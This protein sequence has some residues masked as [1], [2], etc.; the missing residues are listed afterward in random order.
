MTKVKMMKKKYIG[1]SAA[2]AC[3]TIASIC[4]GMA[5]HLQSQ[6]SSNNLASTKVAEKSTLSTTNYAPV[7][8]SQNILPSISNY[9]YFGIQDETAGAKVTFTTFDGVLR[10]IFNPASIPLTDIPTPTPPP[11]SKAAGTVVS[12][13]VNLS[14][15][16]IVDVK[17]LLDQENAEVLV[18]GVFPEGTHNYKKHA[19][20]RLTSDGRYID[21][22]FILF[23]MPTFGITEEA[24]GSGDGLVVADV[25]KDIINNESGKIYSPYNLK[26]INTAKN[27]C[28]VQISANPLIIKTAT[29]DD[30]MDVNKYF[31]YKVNDPKNK[32]V[33]DK[34][35]YWADEDAFA[36]QTDKTDRAPIVL[37]KYNKINEN[38]KS[39]EIDP[40]TNKPINYTPASKFNT[41][42]K[43]PYTGTKKGYGDQFASDIVFYGLPSSN[44]VGFYAALMRPTAPAKEGG[45]VIEK[46]LSIYRNE[47]RNQ[48][49]FEPYGKIGNS[50]IVTQTNS[51]SNLFYGINSK[52]SAPNYYSGYTYSFKQFESLDPSRI[53][54]KMIIP[55]AS[56]KDD[57]CKYTFNVT[58]LNENSTI[59]GIL[60]WRFDNWLVNSNNNIKAAC[61]EPLYGS[62]F[63]IQETSGSY[64]VQFLQ[65]SALSNAQPNPQG[66][67]DTAF[68]KK[69][70]K[71]NTS[72]F[73]NDIQT[74]MLLDGTIFPVSP[75][76]NVF[77]GQD[78]DAL[79]ISYDF[80]FLNFGNNGT[81][82]TVEFNWNK[83]TPDKIAANLSTTVYNI[84]TFKDLQERAT[85]LGWVPKRKRLDDI[86]E[87]MVSTIGN[88]KN[89][90]GMTPPPLFYY[91]YTAKDHI[92][93]EDDAYLSVDKFT[94]VYKEDALEFNAIF[95]YKVYG[96]NQNAND[97]YRSYTASCR[98]D[99]FQKSPTSI[100][101]N[102]F[103]VPNKKDGRP[104]IVTSPLS[105]QGHFNVNPPSPYKIGDQVSFKGVE[106]TIGAFNLAATDT[107]VW[108]FIKTPPTNL[109]DI[110]DSNGNFK[111]SDAASLTKLKEIFQPVVVNQNGR[112]TIQTPY[113]N[114]YVSPERFK[115]VINPHSTYAVNDIVRD[116][117]NSNTLYIFTKAYNGSGQWNSCAEQFNGTDLSILL[118]NDLS[119]NQIAM[120][121][122][123]K[124]VGG[125]KPDGFNNNNISFAGPV[126][127]SNLSVDGKRSQITANFTI[128]NYYDNRGE[129]VST[130]SESHPA[131]INF[132]NYTIPTLFETKYNVSQFNGIL[133][134]NMYAY[135]VDTNFIN[136][137]PGFVEQIL[138]INRILHPEVAG[139]NDN[140]YTV[141]N[142]SVKD[143]TPNNRE[144]LV[145]LNVQ[146]NHWYD[147]SGS[148]VYDRPQSL[149]LTISGFKQAEETAINLRDSN[150]AQPYQI[151]LDP[152]DANVPGLN[153]A[154]PSESTVGDFATDDNIK[155]FILNYQKT[156]I[157]PENGRPTGFNATDI[158]ILKKNVNSDDG[159]LMV[160]LR[161]NKYFQEVNGTLFYYDNPP[162]SNQ[163][164]VDVYYLKISGFR[165]VP[166][167]TL[168]TFVYDGTI[169]IN[170][171]LKV[172]SEWPSQLSFNSISLPPIP[173][174][175]Y[176]DNQFPENIT[177]RNPAT[178]QD[179]ITNH[180]AGEPANI[181]TKALFSFLTT[182]N[183]DGKDNGQFL[184]GFGIDEIGN[185]T[186]VFYNNFTGKIVFRANLKKF[187][188]LSEDGTTTKVDNSSNTNWR[189][190]VSCRYSFALSGFE[191]TKPVEFVSDTNAQ[192]SPFLS[193]QTPNKDTPTIFNNFSAKVNVPNK[194]LFDIEYADIVNQLKWDG[195]LGYY[196]TVENGKQKLVYAK[197][198][199]LVKNNTDGIFAPAPYLSKNLAKETL[200]LN[201]VFAQDVYIF[202]MQGYSSNSVYINSNVGQETKILSG[203]KIIISIYNVK[204]FNMWE[205]VFWVAIG[206]IIFLLL[207]LIIM[208][209]VRKKH[210]KNI[211]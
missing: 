28:L 82:K 3:C 70:F 117:K 69:T 29:N 43:S 152:N 166:D 188:Q 110:F 151:T 194:N 163:P 174:I 119:S 133:N 206:V 37:L 83:S 73:G 150:A 153:G 35:K 8:A 94:R 86:D 115:G 85:E 142:F 147:D 1:W 30:R 160:T 199:D 181:I 158:A 34:T 192:G 64:Q 165:K 92:Y 68:V 109:T 78:D 18:L 50:E 10:W 88:F 62:F 19:I 198:S 205:I 23:N 75:S 4:L 41:T 45:A 59:S 132:S 130:P 157:I 184:S 66:V 113:A 101:T 116:D 89:A 124:M 5:N 180:L 167:V 211:Y 33:H 9:G 208:L 91:T 80:H 191:H 168:D 74:Q 58:A 189:T 182:P 197:M 79:N 126:H 111:K 24:T 100:T 31:S 155:N 107:Y 154:L 121:I 114:N 47:V 134:E 76:K 63:V 203:S 17:P 187:I 65:T 20:F 179:G 98:I 99:N 170:S 118:P 135:Q 137:N 172:S 171:S 104:L 67:I 6:S 144:G 49:F 149:I 122:A 201:Y 26:I 25:T 173:S 77:L 120:I 84:T 27:S 15:M 146:L 12:T 7:C 145:D 210:R 71:I 148:P 156:V 123:E 21:K 57:S 186:D 60:G 51:N 32:D 106:G 164:G 61:I 204:K 143:A 177:T 95:S 38:E 190:D 136:K 2:V 103:E 178:D 40:R 169:D 81:F 48:G 176:T 13:I 108:K 185:I 11:T 128:S 97:D 87:S 22:S 44:D 127:S 202:S 161:F 183:I 36:G 196:K 39:F 52:G 90:A 72:S 125:N 131:T 42:D 14:E 112:A 139:A 53:T 209:I 129:L 140:P 55:G 175:F 46:K 102:V 138:E 56:S 200:E 207:T 159:T 195:T 105:Y 96:Q 54:A 93:F 162:A 193:T 16:K 141:A